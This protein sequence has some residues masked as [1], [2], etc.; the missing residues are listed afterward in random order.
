M[1]S[2]AQGQKDRLS[3]HPT[4]TALSASRCARLV[5]AAASGIRSAIADTRTA[6]TSWSACSS[7]TGW[8]RSM[9]IMA[10]RT[11]GTNPSKSSV[12]TS[13]CAA[14]TMLRCRAMSAST[15]S[16]RRPSDRTEVG[17]CASLGREH[18]CLDLDRGSRL[19]HRDDVGS[20]EHLFPFLGH[21]QSHEVHAGSLTRIE[22]PP[23]GEEANRLSHGRASDAE[24]R[25]ESRL[26][27]QFR[28]Q[29]PLARLYPLE[30]RARRELGQGHP[31]YLHHSISSTCLRTCGTF[32]P[33]SSLSFFFA[34]TAG[35]SQTG[36]PS[37]SRTLRR[38]A[39][40]QTPEGTTT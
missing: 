12:S 8:I 37:W 40:L 32:Y 38:S 9:S 6:C 3:P 31:P 30:K 36:S 17:W 34:A 10:R 7:P 28:A 27:G 16:S 24:L 14:T 2:P 18:R 23:S 33:C 26:A 4:K 13:L 1:L 21:I 20:S 15:C 5:R 25:R 35:R 22:D 39:S 11:R 19:N 29:A